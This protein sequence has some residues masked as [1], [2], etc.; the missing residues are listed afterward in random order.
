MFFR[1]IP[2]PSWWVAVFLVVGVGLCVW[3]ARRVGKR[4][5]V[6]TVRR[7]LMVAMV[8]LL[9]A[10]PSIP[11]EVTSVTSNTEVWLVIDRTG[12]MVAEDYG[13]ERQPRI[14][15]VQS[16]VNTLIESMAGARFS[17]QTFDSTMRTVIP[18]TTDLTAVRSFLDTFTQEL[19]EYS[20]GSSPD[21]P[22]TPLLEDVIQ[23]S[24]AAPQNVRFVVFLGDGETSNGAPAP[25]PTAWTALAPYIDGGMVI[26]YGTTQ[27]GMM[28]A[29]RLGQESSQ[30]YILDYS[31]PGTPPAISRIDEPQLRSMASQLG[32]PY[33]HSPNTS[34]IAARA[35]RLMTGAE[36]VADSREAITSSRYVMWPFA[37]A[38]TALLA[39][40]VWALAGRAR[41]MRRA[42]VI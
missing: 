8:T 5:R 41:A 6:A 25:D 18:M 36:L 35:S 23:A 38:L 14:T 34:E 28:R 31:Q 30:E 40:E 21:V 7:S 10:G 24:T 26:G 4:G 19:S 17:V 1:P 16:D 27:G 15:G 22:A 37:L 2:D 39:W 42:H 13:S 33:I 29:Y 3:G 32:V 11:G 20:Q 12:S 9:L